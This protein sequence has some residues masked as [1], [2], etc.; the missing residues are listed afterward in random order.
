MAKTNPDFGGKLKELRRKLG[1]SQVEMVEEIAE[2]FPGKIKISQTTLSNLEQRTELPHVEVL[3]VLS[4]YFGVSIGY[5]YP[6]VSPDEERIDH[7]KQYLERLKTQ[8][9]GTSGGFARTED[10]RSNNDEVDHQLREIEQKIDYDEDTEHLE[11]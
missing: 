11:Y 6:T 4:K 3:E 7:A 8:N 5:F 9:F 10:F 2:F 1:K